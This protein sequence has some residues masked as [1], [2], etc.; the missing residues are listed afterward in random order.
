MLSSPPIVPEGPNTRTLY[1]C[2]TLTY[3]KA[4]LVM[5][6]G[7]LLW[8][9]F[10]FTVMEQVVPSILPIKLKLLG[11]PNWVIG[12]I[13]TTGPGILNMTVC[14]W[15]SFK[16]D[17]YRSRWG[18][19]IP[20]IVSTLPFLCL[21]LALLGLSDNVCGVLQSHA[22]WLRH[23]SPATITIVL[24]A[25]FMLMFQF[26]NMFV[27]SVFWY[28]F[29]DV[30]PAQFLGRFM[31]SFRIVGVGAGA[32]YNYFVFKYAE[33]HMREIFVGASL[34]YFIGFIMMCLMIKE[35]KYPPVDEAKSAGR[36]LAGLKTFF[37]ETFS[38][39]FYVYRFLFTSF[40]A[41]AGAIGVFGIFF[42]QEMG[43]N[44]D[45]IG[46][47]AAI[48]SVAVMAATF[49]AA[50]FI[51]RWHPLR[52]CTYAAV[53]SVINSAWVWIFVTLPGNYFFWVGIGEGI[54]VAF[55]SALVGVAGLPC[56][57]RIFPQSRFGQFC[58][59]Q[60][61]LRS[62]VTVIAGVLA[63]VFVDVVKIIFSG[64][65]ENFAY[66]FNC[67]WITIF[68]AI[69]AYF[70]VKVY[71][72]WNRMGGDTKFH[73][74]APWT[75]KGIEEMDITETTKP[76]RRWLK[77]AMLFFDGALL[78]PI[79]V[80]LG[81]MWWMHTKGQMFAFRWY[82][83][84][85]LPLAILV[86]IYWLWLRR[87]MV[88]DMNAAAA[89]KPLH[90]GLPHHG[91]LMLVGCQYFLL[92]SIWGAEVWVTITLHMQSGAVAFGLVKVFAN[93]LLV[94]CIWLMCRVERGYSTI[95]VE[96]TPTRKGKSDGQTMSVTEP[97]D[98]KPGKDPSQAAV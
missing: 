89:G 80:T 3:T 45:Q 50:I 79:A 51:D 98:D 96:S 20:F 42:N 46:K 18:R 94:S 2:G 92:L 30:V 53:F 95:M 60:A 69:G 90:N 36:G 40:T 93:F 86:G 73:P 29:N 38:H 44:Y 65:D 27:N 16:S 19:R 59:A 15:V 97:L 75:E 71:Q 91:M 47:I 72:E 4:T 76:A 32:L 41:A 88:R 83:I 25:G 63:G 78:L 56:E 66:R 12:A 57:M 33:T 85:V 14:P 17:R 49:F 8:G 70:L 37:S 58:S 48:T 81:M 7:W 84:L 43:L 6:F 26:F 24:I 9:D 77:L 35:G 62:T 68:T 55:F 74:P 1:H 23:F 5:L 39:K 87:S 10:C 61:M 52:I 31:G 54:V 64:Y 11:A 82:G 13:L 28:L 22:A 34:L 67:V 21:F